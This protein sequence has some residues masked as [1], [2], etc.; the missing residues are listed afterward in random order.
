MKTEVK[1]ENNRID[2]DQLGVQ[3]VKKIDALKSLEERQKANVDPFRS[4]LI[5]FTMIND[6]TF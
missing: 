5:T 4:K 3:C 6:Q 2:F 1:D